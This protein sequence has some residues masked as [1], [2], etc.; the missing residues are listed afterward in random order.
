MGDPEPILRSPVRAEEQPKSYASWLFD[1]WAWRSQ[2]LGNRLG[3][4][5]VITP[6]WLT[7]NFPDLA[8]VLVIGEGGQKWVFGATHATEGDVV[9]KLIKP[10]MDMDRVQREILAV[11]QINSV[12]VPLLKILDTGVVQGNSLGD[13][14]WI[15]EQ[16]ITG[17]S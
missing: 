10:S 11:R 6:S 3:V 2:L 15:R 4:T 13:L 14:F 17:E 8:N 9:L 7:H 12:R 5:P 16:R 1:E